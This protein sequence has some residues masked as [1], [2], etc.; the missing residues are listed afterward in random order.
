VEGRSKDS[1]V[2]C[3][4]TSHISGLFAHNAFICLMHLMDT[5]GPRV[6]GTRVDRLSPPLSFLPLQ[7]GYR[8]SGLYRSIVSGR[9]S[10]SLTKL[11][12]GNVS[13]RPTKCGTSSGRRAS[14]R[15]TTGTT[16]D[17]ERDGRRASAT[18][19]MCE[20]NILGEARTT[21]T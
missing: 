13:E 19:L 12:D 9:R 20:W 15:T 5:V 10:V 6:S 21:D 16:N 8:R 2:T 11:G 3:L 17:G 14:P 18:S 1:R 4:G 7:L